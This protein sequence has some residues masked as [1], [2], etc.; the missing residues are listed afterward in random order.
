MLRITAGSRLAQAACLAFS[1][2]FTTVA[3]SV[4]PTVRAL[5]AVTNHRRDLGRD[6]RGHVDRRIGEALGEKIGSAID[7]RLDL[8]FGDVNIQVQIK[9]QRDHRA[10]EGTR[11]GHLIQ[12][13]SLSELALKRSCD[14][15]SHYFRAGAG[16]KSLYLD[17]GVIH[18]RQ[19]RNG[20]LPK[21]DP[22]HEKDA[23]HQEGGGDRPQNERP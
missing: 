16:I 22:T 8:L 4:P 12:T 10:P 23:D 2:P 20:Q 9:L 13:R 1:T 5:R 6:K 18:L 11:G 14:R 17:G 3:T 15:R 19:R 21:S 7:G